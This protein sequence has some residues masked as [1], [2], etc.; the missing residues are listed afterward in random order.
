M[1]CTVL[2]VPGFHGS[3]PDHWQSWLERQLPESRRVSGI[4]WEA[5]VLA[6][7]AAEVRREIDAAASAVWLVA[8]SFGCLASVVAAA[9]RPEKVAGALLVAPADPARFR[10]VLAKLV[11]PM[12][13]ACETEARRLAAT[14]T[15]AALDAAQRELE[16][17][18]A[19]LVALSKV[20]PAVREDEI[21]AIT[22]ELEDIRHALSTAA[23][24]L[25]AIR[26]VCSQD[27]AAR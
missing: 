18:R 22:A 23:P 16:A 17:E 13:A 5:P 8:H 19:R 12:L 2:I 4:D 14:E 25:D 11:P 6:R 1:R 20:N 7:W 27:I 24:R 3:G 15:G 10:P 9:D 26:F 21:E